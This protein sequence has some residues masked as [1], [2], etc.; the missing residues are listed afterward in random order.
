MFT[1]LC[2]YY[3]NQIPN[4]EL[5]VNKRDHP[6]L[7]TDRTEPYF[8]IYGHDTPLVSHSYSAYTPILS[9]CTKDGYADIPIPTW[10]D[11]VRVCSSTPCNTDM[12]TDWENKTP[13]AIFRGSST[14]FGICE[15]T[16]M[17]VKVSLLSLN[18]KRDVDGILLLNAG[19]TKWKARPRIHNGRIQTFDKRLVCRIPLLPFMSLKEQ[20]TFKYIIHIDGHV[21]AFRLSAELGCG[22]VVL[23]VKSAYRLWYS[24]LLQSYVHYVPIK[25]D[26]SDLY[27]QICWCKQNDTQCQ[28][29]VYNAKVFYDT[30]LS[31]DG[32]MRY[33]YRLMNSIQLTYSYR[34]CPILIPTTQETTNSLINPIRIPHLPRSYAVFKCL[35]EILQTYSCQMVEMESFNNKNSA[36]KIVKID[37]IRM[38]EKINKSS[39]LS[40]YCVGKSINPILEL[41][42]NF[43][44]TY[45]Y[46]NNRVKTEYIEDSITLFD[47]ISSPSFNAEEYYAIL[48][49]IALALYN[50]QRLCLFVHYDLY[51]WN[52]LLVK[53]V[54]TSTQYPYKDVF[55]TLSS[56][57]IPIIIDYDKSVALID[58]VYAQPTKFQSI[59]DILCILLSTMSAILTSQNLCKSDLSK[60]FELGTFFAY[61]KFT[62]GIVFKNVKE[63]KY[64]L[65]TRKKYSYM[66]YE[67]KHELQHTRIQDFIEFMLLKLNVR[68]SFKYS[69]SNHFEYKSMY[70][71]ML[72]ECDTFESTPVSIVYQQWKPYDTIDFF[73]GIVSTIDRIMNYT[74]EDYDWCTFE[75]K[76]QSQ[77]IYDT[78]KMY[79]IPSDFCTNL[80]ALE[81]FYRIKAPC[82]EYSYFST[83]DTLTLLTKVSNIQTFIKFYRKI[84]SLT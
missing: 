30:I 44:Y 83:L 26:L 74:I 45:T 24:H 43:V 9:M 62:N 56:R 12:S 54:A 1:A 29:I 27:D 35:D 59:H 4:V 10:D 52:V 36:F 5:F 55:I 61:P 15:K 70:G 16:N 21:S 76:I 81:C 23:L 37:C 50:A 28:T 8:H 33:L 46:S 22:S 19:I 64:F 73:T 77:R 18:N 34:L 53:T 72:G 84:N 25:A 49:H 48:L 17:R 39:G 57:F 67:P 79:S 82:K 42:P 65:S 2:E 11:W 60:I 71:Y 80:H 75:D 31:Y 51:P 66:Y 20:T 63:L 3:P 32:I 58:D 68:K 38:L 13:T 69:Y 78:Y 47:Y 6:L 7:K 41:I 14:G 40:E